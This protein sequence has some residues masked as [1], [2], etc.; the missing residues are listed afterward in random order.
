[1]QVVDLL[2]AGEV[3]S[4]DLVAR[5][6]SAELSK[7]MALRDLDDQLYPDEEDPARL[8]RARRLHAA[9]RLWAE[10]AG[11]LLRRVMS[12]SGS[13]RV[14]PDV[15]QLRQEIGWARALLQ[16]SPELVLERLKK[17]KAG[18]VLTIAEARRELR[19]GHQS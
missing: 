3:L 10:E 14:R 2:P 18:D 15:L 7:A 17:A 6:V 19:A 8:D 4:E 9:W 12:D 16:Q 5:W 11:A 13:I 1:M